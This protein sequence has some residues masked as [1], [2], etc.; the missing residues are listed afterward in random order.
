MRDIG[1]E[2]DDGG[3]SNGKARYRLSQLEALYNIDADR[4]FQFAQ[5]EKAKKEKK[6]KAKKEKKKKW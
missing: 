3:P 2:Y 6:E 1:N 5:G 4:D